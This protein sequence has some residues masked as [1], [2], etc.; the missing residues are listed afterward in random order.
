MSNT[1]M[2]LFIPHIFPNFDQKYITNAFAKIGDVKEVD[3]IA[4][5]DRD[6]KLFN[7]VYIH[8]NKWYQDSNT[9][10]ILDYINKYGSAK[11][12]HHETW[13]WIVLPNT[14]K[15]HI[16]GARKVTLDISGLTNTDISS[17]EK[18]LEKQKDDPIC[19]SAPEKQKNITEKS[20]STNLNSKFEECAQMGN[21]CFDI[22]EW[23]IEA[24]EDEA[25]MAEIEAILDSEEKALQIE[26]SNLIAI[27][28]RYVQS[29][30]QENLMLYHELKNLKAAYDICSIEYFKSKQQGNV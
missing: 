2:S 19:P 13:Y 26:D 30:E 10:K 27:D 15:K 21:E 24:C 1:I 23:D 3:F 14:A 8:F 4:K 7:A 20:I 6:G 22:N 18:T 11:F 17:I 29:L 12:Y 28:Y 5:K 16:P 25:N 9:T